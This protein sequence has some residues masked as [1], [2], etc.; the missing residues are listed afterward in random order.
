MSSH[1]LPDSRPR[2]LWSGLIGQDDAIVTLQA[3]VRDA[4]AAGESGPAMTMR[5]W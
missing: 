2:A 1:S 3:A 4:H 5:G